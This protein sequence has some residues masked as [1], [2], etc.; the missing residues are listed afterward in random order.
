MIEVRNFTMKYFGRTAV[1]D[2]SF[3]IPEG[4]IVGF[5]GPNGAGKTTTMRVLTGYLAP[6]EGDVRIDG[7]DVVSEAIRVRASIGYLPETVALYPEM[8]VREYLNYRAD[9]EGVRRS[10]RKSRVD[11]VLGRCMIADVARRVTGTLSKGYRQRVGLAGAL[12]HKPRILILDEPTVGLDPKQI[13]KIRELIKELGREHT[14]LLSTHILPEVEAV[15]DRVLIID[16]GRI[17]ANG[18]PAELRSR[19]AG[20]PVVRAVFVGDVPAQEI[21]SELDGVQ[22]ITETRDGGET[23]VRLECREG[24]DCREAVFR[25]AVA[26]HWV[27]RELAA[28]A[29]TLEDVFVRLTT[30]DAAQSGAGEAAS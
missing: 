11:E 28:E 14:V 22:S 6:T 20:H 24:I 2:I 26:N 16:R 23:R 15:C 29:L 12:V 1:D 4:A 10:D 21:L 30:Q 19:G 8:R 27:M 13:I 7:R 5:L 9:L 18:T 17:V 3:Q 25:Q